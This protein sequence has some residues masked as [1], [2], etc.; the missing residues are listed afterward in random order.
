MVV[1]DGEGIKLKII[2]KEI[3]VVLGL[4]VAICIPAYLIGLL[5]SHYALSSSVDPF[6]TTWTGVCILQASTLVGV[7]VTALY[8]SWLLSLKPWQGFEFMGFKKPDGKQTLVALLV[9]LPTALNIG[10]ALHTSPG[11]ALIQGWG[12]HLLFSFLGNGIVEEGV[13]RG[14]FFHYFRKNHSFWGAAFGSSLLWS[15]AHLSMSSVFG[16][17]WISMI[18]AFVL[19]FPFAYLFEKGKNVLWGCMLVHMVIDS[20]Q[21]FKNPDG[22]GLNLGNLQVVSLLLTIALIFILPRWVMKSDQSIQ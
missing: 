3:L 6:G 12:P 11:A 14:F 13:F 16:P 2:G 9:S 22:T 15:L 19:G 7:I 1:Q 20:S 21:L 8:A 4:I 18:L 17:F 5:Y 10:Y